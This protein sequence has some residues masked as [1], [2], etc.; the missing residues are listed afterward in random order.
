M[1][2]YLSLAALAPALAFA[3]SYDTTYSYNRCNN[4]YCTA[5]IQCES[6][7]CNYSYY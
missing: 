4:V 3:C 2:T 5:D 7:N 6:N 1:L